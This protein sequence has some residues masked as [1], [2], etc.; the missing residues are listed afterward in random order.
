MRR[1]YRLAAWALSVLALVLV[2]GAS[3]LIVSPPALFS[4]GSAYAAKIV[5]SSVF[6]SGRNADRVL[7]EDVQAPGH[8]LL[9]YMGQTVD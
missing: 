7:A 1:F 6:V 5:C 9:R 2:V 4:V 3:W 8:P